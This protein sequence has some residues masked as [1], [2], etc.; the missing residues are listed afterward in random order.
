MGISERKSKYQQSHLFLKIDDFINSFPQRLREM[1]T[2]RIFRF[3]EFQLIN[4]LFRLKNDVKLWLNC[5]WSQL[6]FAKAEIV[7]DINRIGFNIIAFDIF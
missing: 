7:T 4:I 2:F 5:E 6:I 1:C 3:P